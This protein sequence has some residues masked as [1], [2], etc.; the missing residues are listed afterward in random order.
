VLGNDGETQGL[1]VTS[2]DDYKP[3]A[4]FEIVST[5]WDVSAAVTERERVK[6]ETE[7]R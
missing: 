7:E 1:L 6:A 5:C 3:M 2:E 4:A